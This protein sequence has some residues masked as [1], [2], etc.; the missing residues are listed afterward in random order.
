MRAG[1]NSQMQPAASCVQ[2]AAGA[3]TADC[4][5]TAAFIA[6]AATAAGPDASYPLISII[7]SFYNDEPYLERTMSGIVHQTYANLEVIAIDDGST[8]DGL[9]I[10]E[11]YAAADPRIHVVSK[12]N[13]GVSSSRNAGLDRA[14]GEWVY[15]ADADDWMAHDAIERFV[16]MAVS[17]PDCD[18]V[19]S[20]FFRVHGMNAALKA[21]PAGGVVSRERY[22]H[23]MRARPANLYY[24]SLWNKFF[25]RSLIEEHGMRLDTKVN[26]GEDHIF[27]LGYLR[28]VRRVGLVEKGLY[29]YVDNQDSLLHQGLQPMGVVRMKLDTLGP[30]VD[31]F[32]SVG[33][34]RTPL[35]KIRTLS[36]ALVPSTDYFVYAGSRPLEAREVPDHVLP[37]SGAER[38]ARV[39]ER[40]MAL[41]NQVLSHVPGK[42]KLASGRNGASEQD[43]DG[44]GDSRDGQGDVHDGQPDSRDEQGGSHDGQ[45]DVQRGPHKAG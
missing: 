33:L 25:R 28:Y 20:S 27:I 15:F 7:V 43:C 24:A 45:P 18:L 3:E 11:R 41:G 16:E 10:V 14:R 21:G 6:A 35:Q 13:T 36:F 8:D 9:E 34:N 29:Y 44:Q 12:P 26:F 31:L 37:A 38:D 1:E 23:W 30:Y 5:D 22:L 32:T 40:L 4:A 17:T 42:P 2:P 39:P 19:V